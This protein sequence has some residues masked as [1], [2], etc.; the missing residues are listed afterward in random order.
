MKKIFPI[1]NLKIIDFKQFCHINHGRILVLKIHIL[2]G[3]QLLLLIDLKLG[4]M[5]Y[6]FLT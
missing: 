4:K 2:I 6:N 1:S 3:L 5:L